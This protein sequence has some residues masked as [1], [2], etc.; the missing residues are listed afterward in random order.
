M[1]RNCHNPRPYY[2]LNKNDNSLSGFS[3]SGLYYSSLFGRVHFSCNSNIINEST[4]V[5][6]DNLFDVSLLK[7]LTELFGSVRR[8]KM[9]VKLT[10]LS[11][12]IN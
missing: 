7:R 11:V 10:H 1:H 9:A 12:I 4:L 6:T 3:T 2:E 8:N 5:R